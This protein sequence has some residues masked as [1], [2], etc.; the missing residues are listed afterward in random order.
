MDMVEPLTGTQGINTVVTESSL[1][2]SVC[3]VPV[4]H[5]QFTSTSTLPRARLAALK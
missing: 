4:M 3:S 1:D 2:V 5:P